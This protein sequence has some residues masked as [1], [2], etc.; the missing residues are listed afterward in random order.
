MKFATTYL[1]ASLAVGCG[2]GVE[3][4]P[5]LPP[6]NPELSPIERAMQECDVPQG[7][8]HSYTKA[9]ELETL[10]LGQWLRCSGPPWLADSDG[11]EFADDHTFFALIDDGLGKLVRRTGFGNQGTWDASQETETWVQLNT[12]LTPAGGNGGS[13]AFEDT[14]SRFAINLATGAGI[15]IY[16]RTGP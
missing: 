1:L 8:L 5:E 16:V 7:P 15:S 14:P 10:I 13:P 12:H 4:N 9:S 11:I 3:S 2:V 6:S